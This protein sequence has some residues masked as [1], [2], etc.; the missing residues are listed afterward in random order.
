M[1]AVLLAGAFA[2]ADNLPD[3]QLDILGGVGSVSFTGSM[4]ITFTFDGTNLQCTAVVGDN[5]VQGVSGGSNSCQLGSYNDAFANNTNGNI[6]SF[7]INFAN[8][9]S[10]GFSAGANSI[11]QTVIPNEAG[12]GATY[13]GGLIAPCVV[14]E[15]TS[16]GGGSTCF[17]G[18]PAPPPGAFTEFYLKFTNVELVNGST[19]ATFIS[20]PDAVSAPEPASMLLLTGGIGVLGIMRRKLRR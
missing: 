9:Q 20:S 5:T 10:A 17:E 12:T 3:P 8:V 16:C 1:T 11:F 13:G 18:C 7:I 14:T 15:S 2:S 4:S 6:Q 19:T